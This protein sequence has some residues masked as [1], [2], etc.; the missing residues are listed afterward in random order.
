M[1]F[2]N[3]NKLLSLMD[4]NGKPPELLF[5]CGNRT[6]G[7]TFFFKRYML[8]RFVK[9]G[10]KFVVFV[11]FI[12]DISNCAD[13]FFA[14]IGPIAFPGHSLTQASILH[15]KAAQLY[16]DNKPCGY[17]IALND[18]ERIK[19]NSALFADAQRGFLD[20]F[21]SEVGKYVKDEMLKFNSIRIS[22]ARGGSS[23]A[24]VRYFPV[25]LCSNNVTVF[26]PYFD[27]YRI[28]SR[29]TNRTHYMRGDGWVLEQTFNVEASEA[30]KSKFGSMSDKELQ[31]AASNQYLLD[32]N[33]F[34]EN[35]PGQKS[36]LLTITYRGVDY[37]MWQAGQL[38]Y[39]SDKTADGFPSRISFDIDDHDT[40]NTLTTQSSPLV[41]LLRTAYMNNR[42]RFRSQKCKHVFLDAMALIK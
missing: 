15:G 25:Y 10:E 3:G 8:R 13:G 24:H 11:R 20:E 18:P 17:V 22:I 30:I 31:Y 42:V 21:Q 19:R 14:D 37:G 33:K 35:I 9:Y 5:C 2:Y 4:I 40:D 26:N 41:K 12:D 27:Y 6:A 38:Y 1:S 36:P 7:K 29:I 32:N 23:G 16:F 28:G 34:V 39:V